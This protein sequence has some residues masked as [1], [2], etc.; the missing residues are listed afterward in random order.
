MDS[1]GAGTLLNNPV[2]ALGGDLGIDL[3]V[4]ALRIGFELRAIETASSLMTV[5][6]LHS[7]SGAGGN[8]SNSNYA[9]LGGAFEFEALASIRLSL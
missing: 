6:I 9:N 7:D 2:W 4:S 1:K 5:G 8:D 3:S